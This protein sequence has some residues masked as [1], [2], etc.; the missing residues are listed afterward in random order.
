V[1][2]DRLPDP[3]F[4]RKAIGWRWS[5]ATVIPA[6]SRS[7][8]WMSLAPRTARNGRDRARC[9]AFPTS[10]SVCSGGHHSSENE[11]TVADMSTVAAHS[12]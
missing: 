2:Y 12:P 9:H 1:S 7:G 11:S 5:E 8:M 3:G 10:P 4:R 6:R